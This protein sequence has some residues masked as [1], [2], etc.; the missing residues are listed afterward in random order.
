MKKMVILLSL[1]LVGCAPLDEPM[2]K[3]D[4]NEINV[5]FKKEGSNI[6]ADVDLLIINTA[7][8]EFEFIDEENYNLI[9]NDKTSYTFEKGEYNITITY[10][11]KIDSNKYN[12][13]IYVN[14]EELVY[15]YENN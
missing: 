3:V 5:N 15:P 8:V 13:F 4:D 2:D 1:L 6:I 12:L 11:E 7:E 10:D 9:T 14:D